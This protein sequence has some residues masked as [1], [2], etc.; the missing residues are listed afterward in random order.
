[1]SQSQTDSINAKVQALQDISNKTISGLEKQYSGLTDRLHAQS[2][3]LLSKMQDSESKL[4]QKVQ[5][6]DSAKSAAVFTDEV[7]NKYTELKS[8]LSDTTGLLKRFPLNDYLPG[9][10]SMKTSLDFLLRNRNLPIDKLQ[11]LQELNTKLKGLETELQ[12]ASD[13]QSFVRNREAQLKEQ[14]LN[15]GFAKKLTGINKQVYYYQSELSQYKDMLNDR[16]KLQEKIIETVRNLPAFQKF[17]QRNSYLAA[18]FP[19]NYGDPGTQLLTG[20]QTRAGMQ[21]L[22]TRR[23]GNSAPSS[24]MINPSQYIQPGIDQAQTQ[25]NNLKNRLN[26]L[27]NGGGNSDM[28][29]PDFKPNEQKTKTFLQRLQYGLNI[30]SQQSSG[31]LSSTSNIA[32]TVAYKLSDSKQAGFGASYIIGWGTWKHIRISNQ[33]VGFRSFADIKAKGSIWITGGFEY[34][35]FNAFKSLRE[36]KSNIS[37][38]QKS[39][40]LGLSKKYKIGSNKNGQVQVLYDFLH[41]QQVPRTQAIKF[42]L[43]YTF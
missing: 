8:K 20:L 37:L 12:K 38:W 16:N 21:T 39:A 6:T 25:L 23:I 27:T 10:D 13:I 1:M 42:R 29:M 9:L 28:T 30:Q 32:A 40:L 4:Q 36:L 26:N 35:Y 7:K 17:W 5:S 34:N 2:A 15:L 19:A 22:L 11:Q 14:L 31:F 3:K 41:N 33:G 24:P 18:L 43:G